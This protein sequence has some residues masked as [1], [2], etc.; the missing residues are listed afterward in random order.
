MGGFVPERV[1][2]SEM[3]DRRSAQRVSGETTLE[4]VLQENLEEEEGR[5]LTDGR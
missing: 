4:E 2:E 3:V 1:A 5:G